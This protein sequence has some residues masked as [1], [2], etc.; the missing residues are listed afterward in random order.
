[1]HTLDAGDLKGALREYDDVLANGATDV[2]GFVDAVS[3]LWRIE[4]S[5]YKLIYYISL[6][7]C[8]VQ[9]TGFDVGEERWTVLQEQL[10]EYSDKHSMAW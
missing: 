1:M 7:L 6:Y 8:A 3:L 10:K 9:C 5:F 2:F 4:V